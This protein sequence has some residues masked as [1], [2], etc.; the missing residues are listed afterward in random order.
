[1]GIKPGTIEDSILIGRGVAAIIEGHR[2]VAGT[3][4]TYIPTFGEGTP[5]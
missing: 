5:P 3:D 4:P 2:D 1:M